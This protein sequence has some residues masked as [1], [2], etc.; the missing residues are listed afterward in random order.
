M[1][2]LY[3]IRLTETF[4][5]GGNTMYTYGNNALIEPEIVEELTAYSERD[6]SNLVMAAKTIGRYEE[7]SRQRKIARKKRKEHVELIKLYIVLFLAIF[8][9]PLSMF[10]HWVFIGY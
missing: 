6:I 4:M 9:F 7:R 10:L 1:M 2:E 3:S 5:N 8:V